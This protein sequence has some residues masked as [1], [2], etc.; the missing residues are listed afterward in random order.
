MPI[1]PSADCQSSASQSLNN[2][3]A[4]DACAFEENFPIDFLTADRTEIETILQDLNSVEIDMLLENLVG[5]DPYFYGYTG[6]KT[7]TQA[8]VRDGF[9]SVVRFLCCQR[10]A[11]VDRRHILSAID[12]LL[13]YYPH[14][15]ET[16][17]KI[18]FLQ[19]KLQ[20]IEQPLES[21]EISDFVFNPLDGDD[22]GDIEWRELM[23][24]WYSD[25]LCD[26][27]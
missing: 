19:D 22:R 11:S 24:T 15:Y 5:A 26:G 12:L 8:Q 14:V 10:I 7:T 25:V 9:F 21:F 1:T 23:C 3:L 20:E 2:A 16:V 17:M 4:N 6:K 27:V 13:C 18:Y